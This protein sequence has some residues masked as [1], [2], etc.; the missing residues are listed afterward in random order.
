FLTAAKVADSSRPE[1]EKA[2][3]ASGEIIPGR[4]VLVKKGGT[5]PYDYNRAV[6]DRF[7]PTLPPSSEAQIYNAISSE[8]KI[9]YRYTNENGW[10]ERLIGGSEEEAKWSKSTVAQTYFDNNLLRAAPE[11]VDGVSSTWLQSDFLRSE[12]Y[13]GG[14]K[15]F[16]DPETGLPKM[17]VLRLDGTME[18]ARDLVLMDD[19]RIGIEGT[20][21]PTPLTDEE[22]F[23]LLE[24]APEALL[25]LEKQRNPETALIYARQELEQATKIRQEAELERVRLLEQERAVAVLGVQKVEGEYQGKVRAR[26]GLEGHLKSAQQ[27]LSTAQDNLEGANT[28]LENIADDE[29]HKAERQAQER[30]IAALKQKITILEDRTIPLLESQIETAQDE[31]IKAKKAYDNAVEELRKVEG[32]KGEA[33]KSAGLEPSSPTADTR[34]AFQQAVQDIETKYDLSNKVEALATAQGDVKRLEGELE[35]L[36]SSINGC[37]TEKA[38]LEG[39]LK[40]A[41]KA[42]ETAE[43]ELETAQDAAEDAFDDLADDERFSEA[44]RKE[45]EEG[46]YQR[47][48]DA[49]QKVQ[50]AGD[51]ARKLTGQASTIRGFSD[52]T[53]LTGDEFTALGTS[54]DFYFE[55]ADASG[56]RKLKSDQKEAF[57]KALEAAAKK[58][59]GEAEAKRKS[60]P[61]LEKTAKQLKSKLDHLRQANGR[62]WQG[63]SAGVYAYTFLTQVPKYQALSNA[64][65]GNEDWYKSIR[66]D[67]ESSFAPLY[68]GQYFTASICDQKFD[69][70]TQGTG[71]SYVEVPGGSVHSVASI[72]AER[73]PSNSQYIT[74]H[75]EDPCSSGVCKDGLCYDD[76]DTDQPQTGYFYKI[77]WGVTAPSDIAFTQFTDEARQEVDFN[78]YVYDTEHP[79]PG[80]DHRPESGKPLFHYPGTNFG[81][82][83]TIHLGLG[84]SSAAL[85]LPRVIVDFSQSLYTKACIIYGDNQ[86]KSTRET[87]TETC[88]DIIPSTLGV[89]NFENGVTS[90]GTSASSTP[91]STGVYAGLD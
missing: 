47:Y 58:K 50:T 61:G 71:A 38:R 89:V 31:E 25:D 39:E 51:E 82:Y 9:Q 5:T 7:T 35:G 6:P 17:G 46:A 28:A 81:D 26:E 12:G 66:N 45:A 34:E 20:I 90:S 72:Q 32:R 44:V 56:N 24:A 10:Q 85:N 80:K 70:E 16:I 84:N 49:Q 18:S 55:A 52:R 19:G 59:E 77:T 37:A 67:I 91:S 75:E 1:T 36:D 57:Q 41:K 53:E 73:S 64:I 3:T 30:I 11:Y 48:N 4:V 13:E 21:G 54:F 14:V 83:N 42:V 63:P 33:E 87:I 22:W 65:F 27:D 86:M 15:L 76:E 40:K 88:A 79:Y 8:G 62:H 29:A 69:I 43:G 68:L 74:C 23:A 78:I 2:F 60:I